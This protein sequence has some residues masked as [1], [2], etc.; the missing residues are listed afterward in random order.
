MAH[1][2]YVPR[3]FNSKAR[4]TIR[5]ANAIIEEYRANGFVLTVRQLYYQF[6]DRKIIDN[7][8]KEY[9]RLQELLSVARLAGQI[10]WAMIEDRTR[11]LIDWPKSKS[12][13]EAMTAIAEG[14]R[15][16]LWAGQPRRVEVW[17]EKEAL[18]GVVEQAAWDYRVP[19]YAC[20]GNNSQSEAWRAGKRF[21][22]YLRSEQKVVVLHLGDHD[23]NGI[24]MTRDNRDRIDIF[25]RAG[26]DIELRRIALNMDQID[27]LSLPPN[28]TKE[29]DSRTARYRDEYGDRSWELDALSP[30][31]IDNLIRRH[32]EPLVDREAWSRVEA[33]E[34]EVQAQLGAIARRYDEMA[35]LAGRADYE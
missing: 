35:Y 9:K 1:E 34:A 15:T 3:R 29:A 27:E 4:K 11:N 17:I 18:V 6:V 7:N 20:R 13:I 31:Y 19:Y 12:P 32:I 14:Y 5:Q 30:T 26:T 8:L 16:D 2:I 33:R 23:P 10:D 22:R 24:D 25:T 21:N 28:P